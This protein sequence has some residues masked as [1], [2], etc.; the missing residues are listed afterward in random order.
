[1]DL[2]VRNLSV[3]IGG[4]TIIHDVSAE[5]KSKRF[6]LFWGQTERASLP[7]ST[8]LQICCSL[9]RGK[10]VSTGRLSLGWNCGRFPESS[11]MFPRATPP[12]MIIQYGIL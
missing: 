7:S 9:S 5:V 8:V 11:A 6:S 3:A 10:S 2:E 1:M 4:K 12:L